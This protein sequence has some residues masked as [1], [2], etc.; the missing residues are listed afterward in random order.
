MKIAI[1]G[2]VSTGKTT[3]GKALAEDLDLPFIPENLETVF[4][5][6]HLRKPHPGGLPMALL[7]CLARKRDLENGHD[8]FVVDRSPIDIF[9]FWLAFRLIE[10]PKTEAV[11]ALCET[12][13]ASYDAVVLLPWGVLE[14]DGSADPATGVR[15][16]VNKWVQFNGSMTI[17]GLARHFVPD[18]RII[19]IP[20]EMTAHAD[21]LHFIRTHHA[22]KTRNRELRS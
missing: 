21:R 19:S 10:H 3:L 22:L 4:G 15:R 12:L 6:T 1:S 11:Y 2:A 20:A 17:A 7:D 9:N 8:H 14:L 5:P 18:E 16:Q 13:M